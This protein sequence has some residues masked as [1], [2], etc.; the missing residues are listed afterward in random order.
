MVGY[1][2]ETE[3][4]GVKLGSSKSPVRMAMGQM[5]NRAL[6]LITYCLSG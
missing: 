3:S 5:G 1:W 2:T 6:F 4:M